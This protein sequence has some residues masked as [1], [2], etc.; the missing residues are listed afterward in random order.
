[1]GWGEATLHLS[2]LSKFLSFFEKIFAVFEVEVHISVGKGFDVLGGGHEGPPGGGA[3]GGVVLKCHPRTWG[4]GSRNCREAGSRF[5]L[6]LAA[7][8]RIPSIC[9]HALLESFS[10]LLYN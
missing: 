4:T 8:H 10:K 3:G 1:M 9:P 6:F 2:G 7:G 5:F